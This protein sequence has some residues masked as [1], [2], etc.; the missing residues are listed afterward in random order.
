MVNVL[1]DS[2][3]DSG[4]AAGIGLLALLVGAFGSVAADVMMVALAAIAGYYVS[5]SSAKIDSGLI[6]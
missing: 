2:C 5:L 4:T 6:D 1:G 3:P